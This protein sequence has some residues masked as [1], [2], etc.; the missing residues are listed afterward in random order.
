MSVRA[1]GLV[2]GGVVFVPGTVM[3]IG[4]AAHLLWM[5]REIK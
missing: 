5:C 2:P 1:G 4:P 3:D